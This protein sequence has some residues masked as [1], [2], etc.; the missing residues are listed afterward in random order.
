MIDL[1]TSLLQYSLVPDVYSAGDDGVAVD[2]N[3]A[4]REFYAVMSANAAT[5]DAPVNVVLQES[6]DT[7]TWTAIANGEFQS[8]AQGSNVTR[9]IKATRTKR[10]VRARFV[11]DTSLSMNLSVVIIA[12]YAAPQTTP[13]L[14]TSS[15]QIAL[16][17]G[18]R[19]FRVASAMV[20]GV[21]LVLA[22]GQT[23][24]LSTD[25]SLTGIPIPAGDMGSVETLDI[26]KDD[27][28]N[29]TDFWVTSTGNSSLSVIVS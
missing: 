15:Q 23:A 6:D 19:W 18:T 10:Y 9:A 2:L 28:S 29:G 26:Y 13:T 7:V 22:S 5:A 3:L 17:N 8:L 11:F 24:V 20:N 16:T 1:L 12:A 14:I 27:L 21:R 25:Q 4:S